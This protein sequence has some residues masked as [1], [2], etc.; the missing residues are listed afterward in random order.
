MLSDLKIIVKRQTKKQANSAA[1]YF[2]VLGPLNVLGPPPV[3]TPER[4]SHSRPGEPCNLLKP[5][6]HLAPVFHT[7]TRCSCIAI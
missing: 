2:N 4:C 3:T 5:L 7:S 1:V 6:I